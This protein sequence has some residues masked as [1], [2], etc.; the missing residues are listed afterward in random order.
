MFGLSLDLCGERHSKDERNEVLLVV[1]VRYT[2]TVRTLCVFVDFVLT[3]IDLHI[4]KHIQ[5]YID[6]DERH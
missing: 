5:K 4:H 6:K 1:R 2:F 3:M